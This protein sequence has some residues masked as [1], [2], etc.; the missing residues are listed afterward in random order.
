MNVYT[1]S[2]N[3]SVSILLERLHRILSHGHVTETEKMQMITN[4]IHYPSQN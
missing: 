1:A 3:V 2:L 4:R